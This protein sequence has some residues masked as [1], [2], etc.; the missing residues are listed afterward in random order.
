MC[1]KHP[2][3]KEDSEDY[4]EGTELMSWFLPVANRSLNPVTKERG[5]EQSSCGHTHTHTHT[6]VQGA[7]VGSFG[8]RSLSL[9]NWNH[10]ERLDFL[11]GH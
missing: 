4:M 5:K 6:H 7:M 10:P 11:G 2:S 3:Q 8:K 9:W 1:L